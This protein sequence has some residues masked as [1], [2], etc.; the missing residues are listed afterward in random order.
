[1]ARQPGTIPTSTSPGPATISLSQ[2]RLKRFAVKWRDR[3]SS[4]R[5]LRV[6]VSGLINRSAT[7][8]GSDEGDVLDP[9]CR[10]RSQIPT[11]LHEI[12]QLACGNGA[13]RLFLPGVPCPI[14]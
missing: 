7:D 9:V 1:M 14:A 10:R 8:H 4:F 5:W 13:F 2:S 11:E 12:G 3:D 6:R